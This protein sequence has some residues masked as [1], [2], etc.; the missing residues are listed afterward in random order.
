MQDIKYVYSDRQHIYFSS[1]D[2][3]EL[4]LLFFRFQKGSAS[5]KI[6]SLNENVITINVIAS[7]TREIQ[8]LLGDLNAAY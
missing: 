3:R 1:K 7:S 6:C 2:A 5:Y 4:H 8:K